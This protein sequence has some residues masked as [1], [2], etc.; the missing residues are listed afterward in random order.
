[1]KKRSFPAIGH[2]KL[3]SIL[4]AS[5]VKIL[6]AEKFDKKTEK[7]FFWP[8]TQKFQGKV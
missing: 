8:F 1:M 6:C 2:Q 7:F 4:L 3:I 5:L